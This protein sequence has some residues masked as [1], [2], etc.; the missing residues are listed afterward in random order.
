MALVLI[1]GD[2]CPI[3][4]NA[5]L[6]AGGDA[7]GVF[8]DVLD[9]FRRVDVVVSNLECP[10]IE[11]PSP[12]AKTGPVFGEA[13]ACIN[14]IR[15][16]GIHVLSLAN[17]H[18]LDHGAPGLESTLKTCKGAGIQTVGAGMTLAEARRVLV[19]D[20]AGLRIGVLAMAE[21]EFSVA[22][23][24]SPG[25]NPLDIID[26]VRNVSETRSQV[27]HLIVLLHGGHE[28]LNA[29]SP[30]LRD[31]CRFLV[32]MGASAVVVQHPHAQGGYEHYRGGCI[33]YGQ[34][35]LVMDEEIYRGMSSFHDGMLVELSLDRG[36][37]ASMSLLPF[38]QSDS[39]P[40]VRR[41]DADRAHAFLDA[42]KHK[43]EALLD[44]DYIRDEWR[45][46]CD[47]RK[48][49]YMG[50]LLAHGRLTR[51]LNSNG[52]LAPLLYRRRLLL[53]TRNVVSCETHREAVETIL[54]EKLV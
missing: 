10:L 4:R 44:D 2:I 47:S 7:A 50:A 53:G 46:F 35:A 43:A 5:P 24:D 6:F 12:I 23:A 26:F 30:R 16:A 25:A 8:D 39:G 19:T 20:V 14:A 31:T 21:R 3:G 45:R 18:I 34:G 54:K 15:A 48:H 52:L 9:D 1:G 49:G 41:M 37:A 13:P 51:R 40:G 17:N 33:V 11:R 42:L 28:F 32:E 36:V 29:P 22:E 27:D 38:T